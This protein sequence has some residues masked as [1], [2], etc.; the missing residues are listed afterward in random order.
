MFFVAILSLAIAAGCKDSTAAEPQPNQNSKA[1]QTDVSGIPVGMS[2]AEPLEATKSILAATVR[3]DAQGEMLLAYF[4]QHAVQ[5]K[6]G[7]TRYFQ[8]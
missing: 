1:G 6:F 3:G 4:D 5:G 8:L 7:K 2:S